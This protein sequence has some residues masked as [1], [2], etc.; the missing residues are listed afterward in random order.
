M[1]I[2]PFIWD[3]RILTRSRMD[4]GGAFAERHEKLDQFLH[5][6]RGMIGVVD[7]RSGN[8]LRGGLRRR[9]GGNVHECPLDGD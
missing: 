2:A 1:S 8:F 6:A 9:L 3:V 4:S 7:A 5:E